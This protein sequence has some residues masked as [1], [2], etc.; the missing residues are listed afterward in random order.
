MKIDRGPTS[1][2]RGTFFIKPS[3]FVQLWQVFDVD[4]ALQGCT[5]DPQW[6][7]LYPVAEYS[8]FRNCVT[9]K[10]EKCQQQWRVHE[11]MKPVARPKNELYLWGCQR[12]LLRELHRDAVLVVGSGEVSSVCHCDPGACSHRF[13]ADNMFGVDVGIARCSFDEYK[14]GHGLSSPLHR[15]RA[16]HS[17]RNPMLMNGRMRGSLPRVGFAENSLGR[18]Y[19]RATPATATSHPS[20]GCKPQT[21]T[22]P[23]SH[24]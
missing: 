13:N 4:V 10:A 8:E 5:L 18:L 1:Q 24:Q 15:I 3:T 7:E 19:P 14:F 22:H 20:S 23:R 16:N 11:Q 9:G 21:T 17:V 2:S 12:T 6:R